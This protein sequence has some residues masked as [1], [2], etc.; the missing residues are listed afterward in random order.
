MKDSTLA[1]TIHGLAARMR[2]YAAGA[3]DP[4]LRYSGETDA[5]LFGKLTVLDGICDSVWSADMTAAEESDLRSAKAEL[6]R[7]WNHL[8]PRMEVPQQVLDAAS[9]CENHARFAE[10]DGDDAGKA[11]A[12]GLRQA[13][14]VFRV[15][16][17]LDIPPVAALQ[18]AELEPGILPGFAAGAIA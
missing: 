10:K 12:A 17:G 18:A 8:A 4:A 14:H 15:M 7:A 6:D 2:D 1:L 13:V 11:K 3:F 16:G 9:Q 5:T